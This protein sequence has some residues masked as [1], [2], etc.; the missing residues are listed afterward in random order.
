MKKLSALI[1]A[2]LTVMALCIPASAAKKDPVVSPSGKPVH[3]VEII[4][5][6]PGSDKS[7]WKGNTIEVGE[8]GNVTGKTDP[9]KGD[10]DNWTIWKKVVDKNGKVTYEVAVEGKDYKIIVGSVVGIEE[11]VK[12]HPET[13]VKI[14]EEDEVLSKKVRDLDPKKSI[15]K[16]VK[17]KQKEVIKILV[18][19]FLSK[20]ELKIKPL[21]DVAMVANYNG[22]VTNPNDIKNPPKKSSKTFDGS[23]YFAFIAVLS[24]AGVCFASKKVLSK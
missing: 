12:L 2:I 15:S 16:I 20:D 5:G 8:D 11:L 23:V 22:V 19:Y 14:I 18:E 7:K 1:L 6:V 10:F 9:S 4:G 24:L 3:E 17:T 21:T 13:A